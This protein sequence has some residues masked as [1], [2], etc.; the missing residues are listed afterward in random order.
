MIL[1]A[2]AAVWTGAC[3]RSADAP[4]ETSFPVGVTRDLLAP[5]LS[6]CRYPATGWSYENGLLSWLDSQG[7]VWTKDTFGDFI[8]ELEWKI[9]P[10]TNSGIIF[11]CADPNDWMHTGLEVQIH[12]AGDGTKHGQ[13][14]GI[15]D[16]ASP[17]F[18]RY[19]RIAVTRS[20]ETQTFPPVPMLK[21]DLGD[22]V[23]VLVKKV[24]TNLKFAERN[25]KRLPYNA[26]GAEAANPAVLCDWITPEQTTEILIYPDGTRDGSSPPDVQIV[27]ETGRWLPDLDVRKPAGEWNHLRLTALGSRIQVELNGAQV[28]DI[29]LDNYTEAGR[30]PQRTL[31]KYPVAGR[32]LPR[33]G[34]IALQ[35]HGKPVWF[36]NIKITPQ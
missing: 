8:L 11:R 14:A 19:G 36:R 28:V 1:L 18:Y 9:A 22:A 32:D 13:V 34:Y 15:Y 7:D 24:Y 6:N 21:H 33:R 29:D 23:S 35:D 17:N 3:R 26:S 30:N 10:G 5:D 31:N 12:E 2:L 16:L 25:G 20:G 4:Q 27:Y